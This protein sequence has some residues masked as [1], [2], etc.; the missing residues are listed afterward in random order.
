VAKE[1]IK[2][3]L[4]STDDLDFEREVAIPTP[5]GRELLIPFIFKY[6]DRVAVAELFDGYNQAAQA[7]AVPAAP[8][9]KPRKAAAKPEAAAEPPTLAQAARDAIQADADTL[10]DCASGWGLDMPY[11]RD[12]VVR[13]VTRYPG[14][15]L[16]VV[17]DY[18]TSLTQGRLGN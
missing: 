14:A 3:D 1:R 8:A 7:P 6:R 9:R 10:L 17:L 5:D 13:F 11:S 4:D 15:A 12:N 18:R 2:L 16:A